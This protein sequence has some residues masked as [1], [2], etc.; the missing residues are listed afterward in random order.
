MEIVCSWTTPW[1]F[2]LNI[3]LD[4]SIVQRQHEL[5]L[6]NG[7][8]KRPMSGAQLDMHVLNNVF[9]TKR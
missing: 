2:Q 5:E 4:A 7:T 9:G 3:E 8:L 6:G 1:G